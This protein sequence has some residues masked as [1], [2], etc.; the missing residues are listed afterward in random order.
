[1]QSWKSWN[2]EASWPSETCTHARCAI[3]N[4]QWQSCGDSRVVRGCIHE[5][6]HCSQ[7]PRLNPCRST[8]MS[9][10]ALFARS[11][12][13]L[14]NDR[15]FFLSLPKFPSIRIGGHR[16]IPQVSNLPSWPEPCEGGRGKAWRTRAMLFTFSASCYLPRMHPSYAIGGSSCMQ[17]NGSGRCNE[18]QLNVYFSSLELFGASPHSEP[19]VHRRRHRAGRPYRKRGPVIGRRVSDVN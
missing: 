17:T 13:P 14:R 3:G 6:P 1:L 15:P 19:V 11:P 5:V 12:G 10:F 18:E 8:S 9:R 2:P 16:G 7:K 4:W